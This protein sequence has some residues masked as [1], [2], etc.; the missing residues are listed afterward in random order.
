MAPKA[1]P[2]A[3][4]FAPPAFISQQVRTARRFYLELNPHRDAEIAIVCGG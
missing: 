1:K 3:E 2:G 4:S